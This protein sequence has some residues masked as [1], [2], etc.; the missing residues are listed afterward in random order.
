MWVLLF[1][2]KRCEA[3]HRTVFEAASHLALAHRAVSQRSD[4][5]RTALQLDGNGV[6]PE[7]SGGG[8]GAAAVIP[9]AIFD[10]L[11][12]VDVRI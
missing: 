11:A 2:S 5:D 3:T 6:A 8:G 9:S 1:V 10:S 7:M 4:A 12:L